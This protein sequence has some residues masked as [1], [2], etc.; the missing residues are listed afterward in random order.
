[1]P[2]VAQAL[3]VSIP[4][5]YAMAKDGRLPCIKLGVTGVRFDPSQILDF[6]DDRRVG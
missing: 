3:R 5:V 2:E 6:I 1:M 4:M